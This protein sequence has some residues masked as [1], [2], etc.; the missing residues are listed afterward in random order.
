MMT[1]I[2]QIVRTGMGKALI[3]LWVLALL[4][5]ISLPILGIF[6]HELLGNLAFGFLMSSVLV[7]ISIIVSYRVSRESIQFAKRE[8]LLLGVIILG[9]TLYNFDGKENSDVSIFLFWAMLV[10]SFPVSIAINLLFAGI[11]Y[12]VDNLFFGA[13]K[14]G[15]TYLFIVWFMFF[16][17]G[18]FQWFKLIPFFLGKF[19][20]ARSGP[21]DGS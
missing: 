10:L 20:K 15:Y 13:I 6:Q 2:T 3:V 7:N 21:G 8:W 12:F 9:F 16:L 14:V 17:A 19:Q 5:L 11:S 1:K 18:Y 4:S